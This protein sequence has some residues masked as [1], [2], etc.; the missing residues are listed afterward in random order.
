MRGYGGT[1]TKYMV[2]FENL[3]TPLPLKIRP[4]GLA[5][6]RPSDCFGFCGHLHLFG[7]SKHQDI[8]CKLDRDK[9]DI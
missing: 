1:E 3:L 9:F 2:N 7:N 5:S 8:L 6:V 4:F